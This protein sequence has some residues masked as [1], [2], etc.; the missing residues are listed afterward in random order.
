MKY[1]AKILLLPLVFICFSSLSPIE[2]SID[3]DL[4]GWVKLGKQPVSEGVE[5]DEFILTEEKKDVKRLKIKVLKTS[6]YI[7]S[8]KVIYDGG[9]SENHSI[10]RHLDKGESSRVFNLIGHY[11]V[12]KKILIVYGYAG[13]SYASGK[14]GGAEL[15]MMAKM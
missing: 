5:Y 15:V 3:A 13:K 7:T 2:T 9:T 10:K 6:V 14:K 4:R 8:I 12:I 1:N 11:R